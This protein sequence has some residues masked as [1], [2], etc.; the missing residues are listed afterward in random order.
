MGLVHHQ[1][2]NQRGLEALEEGSI[3]SGLGGSSPVHSDWAVLYRQRCSHISSRG[4]RAFQIA[5]S[6]SP[7]HLT[8]LR[9][10]PSLALLPDHIF[11]PGN[12][13]CTGRRRIGLHAKLAQGKL[14]CPLAVIHTLLLPSYD[15]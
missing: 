5:T 15:W 14:D 2:S 13:R 1:R 12:A 8:P 11:G 9:L 6:S 10:D 7:F 3:A 4:T